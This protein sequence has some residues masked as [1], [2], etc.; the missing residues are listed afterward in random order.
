MLKLLADENFNGEIF[1][2]LLRLHPELDLIRVQDA[3]L[4]SADDPSILAAACCQATAIA[5]QFQVR[6]RWIERC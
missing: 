1:R 6:G 2:G 5:R 4:Q 3:G